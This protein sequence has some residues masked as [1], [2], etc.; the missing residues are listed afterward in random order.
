MNSA[1]IRTRNRANLDLTRGQVASERLAVVLALRLGKAE[2]KPVLSQASASAGRT[3]ATLNE[4]LAARSGLPGLFDTTE[5]AELCDPAGY[6]GAAR[7]L[8]DEGLA[9][10]ALAD[11]ALAEEAPFDRVAE[12]QPADQPGAQILHG[13]P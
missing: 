2:A 10:E 9:D 3:G 1:L 6:T 11:E 5:W 8:A 13:K 7:T 12:R 4:E